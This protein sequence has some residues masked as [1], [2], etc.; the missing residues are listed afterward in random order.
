V[1]KAVNC[2]E[3]PTPSPCDACKQC[4]SITDGSNVDVIEIDAASEPR[5]L[6][7]GV[8]RADGASALREHSHP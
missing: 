7:V 5:L 8:S 6:L 2:A 3:G 1:A 4:T